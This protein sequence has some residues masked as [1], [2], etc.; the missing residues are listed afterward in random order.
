MSEREMP[1]DLEAERAVI[2]AALVPDGWPLIN[3]VACI[4]SPGD[5]YRE[6]HGWI[7]SAILD[8]NR[9][10]E[11]PNQITVA[12]ELVRHNRL[13][14]AGGQAFLA[15]IIRQLP[16]P[17]GAP[18]Y[19]GV[20]RAN[21]KRRTI[22]HAA[23][24]IMEEA[25]TADD[26]DALSDRAAAQ[27]IRLGLNRQ[28]PMTRSAAEI[29]D[30]S[31][32]PGGVGVVE[33]IEHSL[34]EPDAI[35]GISI[36]WKE[37][38]ELMG[39]LRPTRVYTVI[40][41]T[42]V[43]K[44]WFIHY[45][46]WCVAKQGKSV[47]I[48]TTEMS[49]EEV[50]KRLVFMAAGLDPLRIH[51]ATHEQH[52]AISAAE[53]QIAEL[54]LYVCDVGR[55]ALPMLQAEARRQQ[56]GRGLDVLFVDHI[57]HITVPGCS[58]AQLLEEV[59]GGLKGLAMNLD[60]PAVLVSHINR[61]AAR[62]GL[63]LHSAKGSSSIEQDTNVMLALEPV[64]LKNGHW[65]LLEEGDADAERTRDNRMTIRVKSNKNRGGGKG[66]TVRH[67]DFEQGGRFV[68]LGSDE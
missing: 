33:E 41:D 29:L 62:F 56:A 28:K 58:G 45:L 65:T 47:L 57:Q 18:W 24:T 9:R 27:F 13:E 10:G 21:S 55:I 51:G 31:M 32:S 63:G 60:I 22:V 64:Q 59:M 5:F 3:E 16:T 46:A 39:G 52:Q 12:A 30:G 66:W 6:L 8:L 49:G 19:A 42:S 1:W 4:V 36:G 50:V 38:D 37:L 48:V 7:W 34:T 2:A 68:Q 53:G 40:G 23:H 54:P 44:S 67:L 20:V 25:Y 15:D 26:P 17:L 61:D 35:P 14:A 43:G 11:E